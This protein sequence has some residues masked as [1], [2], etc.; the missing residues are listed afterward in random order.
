MPSSFISAACML[1]LAVGTVYSGCL[2]AAHNDPL[3]T[4]TQFVDLNWYQ[5]FSFPIFS[6]I[7]LVLL[8]Y[9]FWLLQYVLLAVLLLGSFSAI[10]DLTRFILVKNISGLSSAS[11]NVTV[12]SV[13]VALVTLYEWGMNG[14][15]IA[16]DIIG[17]S[18]CVTFISV[19]RFPSLKIAALCLTLLFFYD[20]YWVFFSESFFKKNVMLEV[21]TKQ[22][23][24]P[25]RQIGE[26]FNIHA[27]KSAS[28]NIELPLKLLFPNGDGSGRYSMLGLGDIAMPGILCSLA[29]RFDLSPTVD[30]NDKPMDSEKQLP[31]RKLFTFA[32]GGYTVGLLS[33]FYFS[34]TTGHAQPALIYIVPGIFIP[35]CGRAYAEGR[36]A[37]LWSGPKITN[38]E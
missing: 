21:A 25:V 26:H 31:K 19:L 27:L 33:A 2:F 7:V 5:V 23:T 9:Y 8:F 30:P 3:D 12:V 17:C 35:L 20:M 22:A 37:E 38:V 14:N 28:V 24:N 13:F 4:E 1:L 15:F 32:L 6:S 11:R 10:C 29:M 18:L 16:H 36:L 34:M